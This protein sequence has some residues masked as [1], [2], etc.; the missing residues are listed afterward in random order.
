MTGTWNGYLL[1]GADRW[2]GVLELNETDGEVSG[3]L[4][5]ATPGQDEVSQNMTGT[6]KDGW[7]SLEGEVIGELAYRPDN[8]SMEFLAEEDR[9]VGACGDDQ[10]KT[11]QAQFNRQV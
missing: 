4:K 3:T 8:L 7:V 2:D 1:Y 10:G 11:G 9:L 5:I 6:Y